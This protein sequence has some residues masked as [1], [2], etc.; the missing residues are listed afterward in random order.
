M[1]PLQQKTS[2]AIVNIFETGRVTGD[3]A[4]VTVLKGDA[5]H[6]TYGR[7]QTT[8]ASGNLFLLIK[9]Y[10]ER[11]E[12][13][14]ATALRPF[15]PDLAA[16][17]VA[18][19]HNMTLRGVLREAGSDPAMRS[20][21]DRFFDDH[22]FNPAR[23]AAKARGITLPLGQTVVYDSIVHGG[24]RKVEPLVGA[25]IGNGVDEREWVRKYVA[26]RGTWLSGLKPPLPTTVYRMDAFAALIAQ[27]AWDLPL[28]L[29]VRGV[30]ISPESLDD[31]IPVVRVTAAEA[32]DVKAPPIL[33]LTS[34]RMRGVHVRRLQDALTAGGAAVATTGVFDPATEA[35]VRK[36]QRSHGLRVDGVVGPLT[37]ASLGL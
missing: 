26:A 35:A 16:R 13:R 31:A 1:N 23:H 30:V 27:N 14:L 34:P 18:L 7:S 29:T 12:A 2:K 3:Y 25:T 19:D 9:A 10:C 20:E 22:Y 21:Q 33:R 5:G 6:L 28:N 4:S 24:F 17:K 8:L 11:R 36:W 32:G 37:R 15:L